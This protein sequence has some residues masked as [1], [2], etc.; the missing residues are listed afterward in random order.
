MRKL[1]IKIMTFE[2]VKALDF[3]GPIK[4]FTGAAHMYPRLQAQT[5]QWSEARCGAPNLRK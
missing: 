1:H 2:G 3:V 4:V 5:Q